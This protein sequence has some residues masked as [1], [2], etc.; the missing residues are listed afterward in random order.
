MRLTSR[1]KIEITKEDCEFLDSIYLPSKYPI[2][3]VLPYYEP[4]MN[5]CDKGITIAKK[6]FEFVQKK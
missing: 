1:I 5:I 6:V 2:S 4:Y 3:S